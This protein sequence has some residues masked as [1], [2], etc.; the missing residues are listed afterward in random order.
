MNDSPPGPWV[1][2]DTCRACDP[3]V[4]LL[5]LVNWAKNPAMSLP[6]Q[7]SQPH[8]KTQ[9]LLVRQDWMSACQF[10]ELNEAQVLQ[11]VAERV[12]R[13]RA[14]A[15]GVRQAHPLVLLDLDS[16]LYEVGP[17]TYHI[18]KE[19][20]E[21]PESHAAELFRAAILKAEPWHVGYSV[22]E[23]LR[24]LGL[25][26]E[27]PEHRET[28]EALK[29]YWSERFFA[30]AYL[31]YDRAYPGAAAF[32]RRLYELG[33][34]IVYLTGRDEPGMGAGTREGLLRD[35]FPWEVDRTHLLMKAALHLPDLDHK[36]QAAHYVR[37]HGTLV[38]SFENEPP[39]LV[40]LRDLFPEAMHV[41]VDTICSDHPA[42]PAQ[43]L[44]RIKSFEDVSLEKSG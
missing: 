30:S 3:L 5:R 33:A 17:R 44:Y 34:E 24:A 31:K 20:A 37:E 23:T 25:P 8:V 19:W 43:G 12:E 13:L 41:F 32:T 11:A 15:G 4:R 39:N 10:H 42:P 40:A 16:T 21:T 7:T 14:R 28:V 22:K 26:A 27:A 29:S 36:V 1:A 18:L 35:G 6:S 9:E 38:A 2:A